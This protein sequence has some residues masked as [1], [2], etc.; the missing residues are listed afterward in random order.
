MD[1]KDIILCEF[2]L[3]ER[4][5]DKPNLDMIVVCEPFRAMRKGELVPSPAFQQIVGRVQRRHPGKG[6]PLV[7]F[8]EDHIGQCLGLMKTVR[9]MIVN[10]PVDQGGPFEY[11]VIGAG[12]NQRIN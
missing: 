12:E 9:K 2:R 8:L 1:E 7:V 3:G 4:G 5:L 10:W 6:T 11:D